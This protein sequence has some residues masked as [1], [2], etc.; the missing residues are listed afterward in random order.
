M[1]KLRD[2]LRTKSFWVSV[3]GLLAL[4][5]SRCGVFHAEEVASAIVEG[6]GG[7]LLAL[8][9]VASPAAPA[10]AEQADDPTKEENENGEAR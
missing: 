7:L 6:I 10:K 3:A 5:L 1:N 4:L 8:G 9:I 2:K